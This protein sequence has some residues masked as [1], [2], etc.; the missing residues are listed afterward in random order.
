MFKLNKNFASIWAIESTLHYA[1]PF[2]GEVARVMQG[3]FRG[4][5]DRSGEWII[6]PIAIIQ[7]RIRRSVKD[8]KF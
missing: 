5:I 3:V 4:L 8:I 2:E 1:T 7:Q 6:P